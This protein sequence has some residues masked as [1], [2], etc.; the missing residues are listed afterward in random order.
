MANMSV[1]IDV[2][3][4]DKDRLKALV[5]DTVPVDDL[6]VL[7]AR[8]GAEEL[9]AQATGRAVFSTL[10]DIR[11]YRIFRLLASGTSLKTAEAL[12]PSLF[13]VTPARARRL[14]EAAVAR[15]EVEL[16]QVVE[17]RIKA[18]LEAATYAEGRW[19]VEL[20][21]GVI[22][23]SV[24]ETAEQASLANPEPAGRGPIWRFPHETFTAVRAAY[25]LKEKKRP[26]E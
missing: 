21:S 14:I 17:D 6:I 20:P 13:K 11:L 16:K 15:Y 22:R 4:D 18:L 25:K 3:P 8:A 5:E 12:A 1:S 19:E 24:L 2:L 10:T 7:L 26:K 23:T 9:L